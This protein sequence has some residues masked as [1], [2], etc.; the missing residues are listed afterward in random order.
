MGKEPRDVDLHA[1]ARNAMRKYEFE[2][3]FPPNVMAKVNSLDGKAPERAAGKAKDLRGLLWSSIDNIDTEDLDQIEYCERG[4]NGEILVK[5]AI[6]D[7]DVYVPK[8]SVLDMHA[9]VNTTSVYTGIDTFP[10]LP[11]RLSKDLSS[12]PPNQDRLAMVAEYSVLPNGSVR[13][14]K[15]YPALVRNKA[16]LV[17]EQVGAWLDGVGPMPK[18]I[19]DTPNLEAQI[20]LQDEASIRLGKYRA[21]QG[22]LELETLEARAVIKDDKVLGLYVTE[23]DRAKRIIENFM[24]GANGVMSGFLEHAGV[25]TIQRVVRIPKYWNEI[26]M[27]ANAK[28]FRLPHSPNAVAL[29]KFLDKEKKA[30]PERFPDLSL[31]V[32]KLLGPGEYVVYDKR[33]PIGHFCLAVTSYTH[34][35]APN[36]RYPD[37]IIQRLLKA[38]LNKTAT[39]YGREELFLATAWCT[40]RERAAKRVERFMTKAEAAV[41]LAGKI[42]QIFD[43]IVTGASEKGTYARLLDPPVEGKVVR[44][45]NRIRV[46]QKVKVRLIN[47]DPKNGFVDF[48][49]V[50]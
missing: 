39:P 5:V 18:T 44:Q 2:P 4:Q 25:P 26:V 23:D 9:R 48:D 46:G 29:S 35:T 41:L 22:A 28:G 12:L 47:L 40:D 42:G 7:V 8:D 10:M 14:G 13:A 36:R 27:L 20:R 43:A 17:Y 34:A 16:K 45:L 38:A 31:T 1:I 11:D 30:D 33:K 37:L 24:I 6:A 32:V 3:T 49:I 21:G 15:I 19:A 50:R